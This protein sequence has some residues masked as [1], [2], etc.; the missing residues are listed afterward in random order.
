MGTEHAEELIEQSPDA[1][2][3]A[4]TEGVITVWNAAAERVF[5]MAAT[6]SD[7]GVFEWETFRQ[8]L[9]VRVAE[10]EQRPGPFDYYACWLA[11]FEDV[12]GSAGIVLPEELLERTSEFEFGER[13]DIY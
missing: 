8:R 7:V 13:A 5:G 6:L 10:G 12:L 3:F 4:N 1:V 2:I 9:I 11:A